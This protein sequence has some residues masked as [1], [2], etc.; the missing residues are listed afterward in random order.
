MKSIIRRR[1]VSHQKNGRNSQYPAA[2]VLF[3]ECYL[4]LS[5]T[6]VCCAPLLQCFSSGGCLVPHCQR[7]CRVRV[8]AST[9]AHFYCAVMESAPLAA[10]VRSV[11]C[12]DECMFLSCA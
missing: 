4:P 11:A 12:A 6:R 3:S 1:Y 5:R 10:R 8:M 9:V 2:C 7:R